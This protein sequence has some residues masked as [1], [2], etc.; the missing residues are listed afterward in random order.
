MVENTILVNHKHLI[1][2]VKFGTKPRF[3]IALHGFGNTASIF[4][5][6]SPSLELEFT[7]IAIELPFHGKTSW[8]SDSYTKQD[9]INL[10]DEVLEK[11]NVHRFSLM[12]Y[13]LGA[14]IA[15]VLFPHFQQ[16]LEVFFLIAPDGLYPKWYYHP[17]LFPK[18]LRA[19]ITRFLN[20]PEKAIILL[21]TLRKYKL[22]GVFSY[23]F[24]YSQ[25]RS[26]EKCQQ[27]LG[28]WVSLSDFV[29]SFKSF[30][31]AVC[32]SNIPTFLICGEFDAVVDYKICSQ[33]AH[34]ASNITLL[35]LPCNHYLLN[36]HLNEP[37]TAIL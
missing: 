34:Q 19:G 31:K 29:L 36:E 15:M 33:F 37:L 30:K 8:K 26:K 13:S 22:I 18:F 9:M 17:L 4:Q 27:M 14:K 35:L 1:H 11:E 3:L 10:L 7:V 16:Q 20:P 23:K 21:K 32:D 6:L 12:G 28:T 25:L 5:A 24:V 2:Y